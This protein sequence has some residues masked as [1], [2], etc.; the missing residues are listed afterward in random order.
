IL[1]MSRAMGE[2]APILFT[3]VVFYTPHLPTS[4]TSQFMALPYHLYIL[5]TQH[6]NIEGVRPLAYGTALV[7]VI[8]TFILNLAAFF[9]RKRFTPKA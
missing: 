7:L 1:S 2:T 4:L 3:G 9:I 5:A 6:Q 8:L